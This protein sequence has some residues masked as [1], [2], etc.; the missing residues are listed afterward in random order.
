[1]FALLLLLGAGATAAAVAAGGS[2]G[3]NSG[4]DNVTG[5]P[6][7]PV[8]AMPGYD[9]VP[10]PPPRAGGGASQFWEDSGEVAPLAGD[11]SAVEH[12]LQVGELDAPAKFRV[13]LYIR[14]RSQSNAI[15]GSLL[16]VYT[17][18]WDAA[19]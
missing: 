3:V 17:A 2:K 1:M 7:G 13:R 9:P 10:S 15:V 4:A 12:E 16:F 19:R 5:I 8:Q 6:G 18:T 14:G 11:T